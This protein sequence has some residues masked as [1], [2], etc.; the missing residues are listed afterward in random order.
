MNDDGHC[1]PSV[2]VGKTKRQSLWNPVGD[3][4]EFF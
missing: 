2:G 3:V 1:E 4:S